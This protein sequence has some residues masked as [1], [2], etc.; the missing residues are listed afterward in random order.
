M[1]DLSVQELEDYFTSKLAGITVVDEKIE[2]P[3]EKKA[4]YIEGEKDYYLMED[5][6][7]DYLL[8]DSQGVIRLQKGEDSLQTFLQNVLHLILGEEAT[9]DL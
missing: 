6:N 7:Q 2:F 8:K 1:S 4:L 9:F 5:E 3:N